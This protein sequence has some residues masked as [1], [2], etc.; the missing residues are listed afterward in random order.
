MV[1]PERK[2]GI[3]LSPEVTTNGVTGPRDAD[4]DI[5]SDSASRLAQESPHIGAESMLGKRAIIFYVFIHDI[6][7]MP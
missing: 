2:H 1:S 7:C 6:Y 4:D 5:T 3:V